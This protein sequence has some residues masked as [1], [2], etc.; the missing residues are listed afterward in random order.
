MDSRTPILSRHPLDK[1]GALGRGQEL[2]DGLHK[3]VAV[4][5]EPFGVHKRMSLLQTSAQP[6]EHGAIVPVRVSSGE[7][8]C[9]ELRWKRDLLEDLDITQL[10]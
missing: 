3:G 5:E 2:E 9:S 1:G 6:R 8:S 4:R 7:L 10:C